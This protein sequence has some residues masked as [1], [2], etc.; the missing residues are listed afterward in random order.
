LVIATQ[1]KSEQIKKIRQQLNDL[2]P[3]QSKNIYTV[4]LVDGRKCYIGLAQSTWIISDVAE[5]VEK[6]SNPVNTDE[7]FIQYIK[8]NEQFTKNTLARVYLNFNKMPD[9]LAQITQ[10]K[11]SG[12]LKYLANQPA[13]AALNYNFGSDKLLLNGYTKLSN[14]DSYI[15]LFLNQTEQKSSLDLI[16][17][18]QTAN[19][20]LYQISKLDD[21]VI[22][23]NAWQN[24]QQ[25]YKNKDNELKRIGEKYRIDLAETL[26]KYFNQ[27]FILAQLANGENLGVIAVKNADKLAQSLLDLSSPYN[28]EVSVF[29][30][31]S[32]LS[33]Y[34]GEPFEKF[35]RPFYAIIDKYMVVANYPSTVQNFIDN[36]RG[37][38]ILSNT[39]NYKDFRNQISDKVTLSF[40]INNSNSRYL[41]GR[42]LKSAF[43]KQYQATT[44]FSE[45]N[46]FAYQLSGE[47][48]KFMTD[49]LLLKKNKAKTF[50]SAVIDSLIHQEH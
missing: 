36:Y 24:Q 49:V 38:R 13:Y 40:Y 7:A 10:N 17:P 11:L 14:P 6:V 27:Q 46:C 29:K 23:L 4:N 25:Q 1:F 39:D 15:S 50:D 26:P 35:P 16:L 31:K 32:L 44:G 34:F 2:K 18:E 30:E 33:Y 22:A 9:F 42:N 37:N 12:E 41:M 19:Y 48:D 43:Y 8:K 21:W 3:I 47:K 45:Y 5:A 28:T 20:Q